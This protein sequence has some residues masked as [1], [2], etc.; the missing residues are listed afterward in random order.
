MHFRQLRKVSAGNTAS[1]AT[2]ASCGFMIGIDA[3]NQRDS[4]IA[5]RRFGDPIPAGFHLGSRSP[6]VYGMYH[7]DT[8]LNF[9]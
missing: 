6:W 2:L 8:M 3:E 7:G 4:E 9:P 1:S 5:W